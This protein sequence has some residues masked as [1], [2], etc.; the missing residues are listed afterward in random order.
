MIEYLK[1]VT[2]DG[3]NGPPPSPSPTPPPPD[4]PP[5]FPTD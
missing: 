1:P 3:Q 5:Q 2:M 4:P